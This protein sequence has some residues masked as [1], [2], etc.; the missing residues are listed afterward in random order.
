MPAKTASKKASPK[1]RKSSQSASKKTYDAIILGLGSMGSAAALHLARRGL[2]VLGLDRF[3]P[4]H[5]QGSHHSGSRVIRQAYFEHPDYVPLAL[6]SYELW[7]ALQKDSRQDLM[8]LTGALMVGKPNC[9]VVAGSLKAAEEHGLEYELLEGAD[10]YRKFSPF[11]PGDGETVGLFEPAGGVVYPEKTIQAHLRLARRAGAELRYKEPA[12]SWEVEGD[13]VRVTTGKGSYS[14]GRLV[15]AAGPWMSSIAQELQIPIQVTRQ[16]VAWMAPSKTLAPF[17]PDI[18][19]AW[20]WEVE[21]EPVFYGLPALDGFRGGVKVG[22]H[23]HGPVTDADSEER[24]FTERDGEPFHKFLSRHMKTLD[25]RVLRGAVCLYSNTPDG[26]F[27]LGPHPG[28][29]QVLLAG[30]FSGHG[31]KFSPLVG[32]ILADLVQSGDTEHPIGLFA[33]DRFAG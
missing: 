15:L 23:T 9:E 20:V 11:R 29:S 12:E 6:R 8:R 31:F 3:R 7:E 33:P 18:F 32:E 24:T 19:P 28:H 21:G 13:G 27:L 26:H 5:D 30:G 14:A 1:T 2:K 25:G 16:T 10:L 17:L 22:I 4:P